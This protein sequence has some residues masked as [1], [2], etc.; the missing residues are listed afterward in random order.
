MS[1]RALRKLQKQSELVNQEEQDSS[2]GEETEAVVPKPKANAFDLLNAFDEDENEEASDPEIEAGSEPTPADISPA[3]STEASKKKRK[4]KKKKKNTPQKSSSKPDTHDN[5]ELDDIDRALKELSTKNDTITTPNKPSARDAPTPSQ[6][7]PKSPEEV[8][9]IDPKSLNAINE[10]RKLF[11][12]VVL[13][14]FVNDETSSS[15]RRRER[16]RETID[17][18]RAL[19]GRYSP[20]SRGQS[21][22][23]VTLRKN[24]LMQGKDEWPR[25]TSGGLGMELSQKLPND[26]TL[27]KLLHNQLYEN[28][29]MQFDMCVESMDPQRLIH[30]LQYNPYHIST[31]L[32]VSEIAKHQSDHAVS[33]DLLERAL[34]NIGRSAHS[35]FASQLQQGKANLDFMVT[36]NRELWLVGWRYI[37]NLGM[38]GT[39]RTAYEW[40]KLLLSLDTKDPYCMRLLIDQLALR[41][42]QYE[43][44]ISLCTETIF[45]EEW[46]DFPNVQCSLSLA[47][48]RL[49][50]PQDARQQLRLAMS[51]YPWVFSRLAQELDI[52]PIPKRIWGKIPPAQSHELLTELYI[53]RAKDLWNTPEVVSLVVEIADMLSEDD[54]RVEPPEITL[55]IARHVVLSD[56]PKV[57]T[58]LPTRFTSGKISASDPLP[59]YDSEAFRQQ[60]D[61][62]PSYLS[63]VPEIARP[64]WLRDFLGRINDDG[65]NMLEEDISDEEVIPEL[66]SGEDDVSPYPPSGENQ[67]ELR[68][69]LLDTG[70]PPLQTFLRQYGV[71]RGNW[72]GVVEDDPLT[73]YVEG[74]LAINPPSDRQELLHGPIRSFLGD[75]AIELL[76]AV[77]LDY[78]EDAHLR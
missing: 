74:L 30:L 25:A 26:N 16:Q 71:D 14:S 57:T 24:V 15:G 61:P 10:M 67:E 21:L 44:F 54:E 43:H 62:T 37:L 68:A 29:Q 65:A 41:G 73:S 34:F 31:L 42:R 3:N 1:S 32:Q 20:A 77:L 22:A 28:V 8:L 63:R 38:K 66:A 17:L 72:S 39:W 7:F 12:N 69:W 49:N 19:S 56:I 45:S 53:S 70:I 60:A 59:P 50:K 33:A 27:Y 47:Y 51:R 6:R 5:E 4:K 13:E 35:S 36:E 64:Q 52:Q 58:H 46:K 48:L 76:Q 55:D 40:A 18:G 23:G 9:T 78:E 11:G 2:S 75:M